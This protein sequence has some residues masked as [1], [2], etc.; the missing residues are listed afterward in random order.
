MPPTAGYLAG[1]HV[2]LRDRLGLLT[3]SVEVVR[4]RADQERD[5]FVT[6]LRE[7]GLVGDDP[8][9]REIV[10]AMHMFLRQTPAAL[11]GVQLVDAVGERR[12]QNQPGTDK[13]YPNWKIPLGDG[14]GTPILLEDLFNSQRLLSLVG[15]L[16]TPMA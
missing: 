8:S 1:E 16:N 2:D 10:E 12:S 15:V 7:R 9:E 13:E 4:E 11:L 14:S 3:E 6:A 5:L